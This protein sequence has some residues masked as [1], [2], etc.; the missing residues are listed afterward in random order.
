MRPPVTLR[1]WL[2]RLAAVVSALLITMA[3]I[4]GLARL[5]LPLAAD[6]QDDI[7]HLAGQATGLR[8]EFGRMGASWPLA[9]PEL[10]LYDVRAATA[11]GQPVL[12]AAELVVGINLAQALWNRQLLPGR[13]GISG[14]SVTLE[15][16]AEGDYINGVPIAELWPRREPAA[17]P[18][19]TIDLAAIRVRLADARRFVPQ[20]MFTIETLQ[21]GLSP[22]TVRV[23][24]RLLPE[25]SLARTVGIS[26]SVPST[27]LAAQ[28]RVTAEARW[29][30]NVDA[31]GASP[32][33]WWSLLRGEPGILAG[34]LGDLVFQVEFAGMHPRVLAAS[35]DLKNLRLVQADG[36][37]TTYRRLGGRV[38]WSAT[39]DG[40][41]AALGDLTVQ[42]DARVSP[43]MRAALTY[44]RQA[45]A[46]GGAL[47]KLDAPLLQLTELYPAIRAVLAL[48]TPPLIV[49]ESVR[50][51]YRGLS[52]TLSH[53]GKTF[54]L[55]EGAAQL[56][57]A[58]VMLAPTSTQPA[59]GVNGISGDVRF[60]AGGGQL[61]LDSRN[62][63]VRLP[64]IFRADVGASTARGTLIW[65]VL[66]RGYRLTT[67]NLEV[68][69]GEAGSDWRIQID[70]PAE[71]SPFLDISARIRAIPAKQALEYLPLQ[72]FGRGVVSWLDRAIVA[73]QVPEARLLWKGPL[74]GTPYADGGGRFRVDLDISDGILDYA[75]GWPRVEVA[76]AQLVID[77][78]ELYSS[79]NR[80]RIGG[81]FFEDAEVRIPN[82]SR[83]AELVVRESGDVPLARLLTFLRQ[84]P[85]M[86]GSGPLLQSLT[87]RGS[88]AT[89]LFLRLPLA[90]PDRYRLE[91]RLMLE[92]GSLGLGE[93]D[94]E[95]NALNGELVLE[96]TR[97]SARDIEGSFLDEPVTI[98]LQPATLGED[99]RAHVAWITGRTPAA[100]L[101]AAFAIP[102]ADQLGG[103]VGWQAMVRFPG[104]TSTQPP[105]MR[106]ESDLLDLTSTIAP[107]L[108]KVSGVA[109]PLELELT[110]PDRSVMNLNGKLQRGIAM[111]IRLERQS[112]SGWRLARGV[113]R[114][115]GGAASL[116]V[117]DGLSITGAFPAL[118]LEDWLPGR[119]GEGDV[120]A[121]PLRRVDLDIGTLQVLGRPLEDVEIDAERDGALWRARVGGPAA[122]GAIEA[123]LAAGRVSV[124]VDMLRLWLPDMPAD[125]GDQAAPAD[126][127]DI[128]SMRINILDFALGAMRFG[129]LSAEVIQR[130]DGIFVEPLET[131]S[132]AF[133]LSGS[134]LWVV[135]GGDP[136]A[137]RSELRLALQSSDIRSALL[138]LAYDPVL[139]G[140]AA[141][142]DADLH[143]PGGLAGDFLE[144]ASGRVAVMMEGG[145]V[146]AVEPGGGR[147]LGLLSITALPRRLGMD[148][149]D[150]L[151]K[152]LAF[153]RVQGDFRFDKGSALTCNLGLEGPVAALGVVGRTGF[154]EREYDQLVVARSNVSDVLAIGGTVVGGPV[155]GG[156]AFLIGQLFRKPLGALGE[157]YYRIS[158][159]WE[160]PEVRRLQRADV[161]TT[162]FRDCERYFS[163][164]VNE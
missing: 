35:A 119:E 95:V 86:R 154:R 18:R 152:G 85:V 135:A 24:G 136:D 20:V 87:A 4:V 96:N 13:L 121:T 40:W 52:L 36:M 23:D 92:N 26:G 144:R 14:L 134:A 125:E 66:A 79:E 49:P 6:Y 155:V 104:P 124:S 47:L 76:T 2:G 57:D 55:I 19:M 17:L 41:K 160:D 62:T 32:G 118:R 8:I 163:E 156:A 98:A 130:G 71:G 56:R 46:D 159:S 108:A 90:D 38:E 30:L 147:L 148:F 42:Q 114:G 5:L 138:A 101:A 7:R 33:E 43:A 113:V 97:L 112:G 106:I 70:W 129:R 123:S 58:G 128:P 27:L 39:T 116:P 89:Q 48:G 3:V 22:E 31:R 67:T 150:V 63:V 120:G 82:L 109:E 68:V 102:F 84:T 142:L 1:R 74:A 28:P 12:A 131:R 64:R 59:M 100:K 91:G 65:Q 110:W 105:G 50:G 44:E 83:N 60:E 81:V 53:D 15:R 54:G 162:P 72:K 127:R 11:D 151:D 88:G 77:R 25:G 132:P 78:G 61:D 107:P 80:G 103:R 143:W 149:R 115:G 45:G 133:S 157:N 139:S 137:Q 10:R 75:P 73:G 111:A 140:R 126:P 117:D 21:V 93:A 161:D 158:G 16:R 146:L 51:E 145:Q 34:G 29:V 99:R 141:Q 37:E 153:D 122:E 164:V 9:G 69:S 94:L